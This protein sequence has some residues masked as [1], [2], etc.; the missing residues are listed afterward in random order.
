MKILCGTDIVE[1]AH[2]EARYKNS[3][4]R[5]LDRVFSSHEQ[6][7]ANN[8]LE[9]WAGLFAGKEAFAKALGTGLWGEGSLGFHDI[10][11]R[12]T[13]AGAPYYL[14]S[15]KVEDLIQNLTFPQ[16]M[17]KSEIV[18]GWEEEPEKASQ[19]SKH[20]DSTVSIKSSSLSISHD[21]GYAIAFCVLCL[22]EGL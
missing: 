4:K 13:K 6:E 17:A 21:G 16:G 15:K 18:A 11:I 2:F 3:G 9:S 10:E 22:G 12:K 20:P 5:L 1:I 8:K 14:W 19:S 7:I